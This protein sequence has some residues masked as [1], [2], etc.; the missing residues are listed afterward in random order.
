MEYLISVVVPIYNSAPYIGELINSLIKQTKSNFEIVFIDDNSNDSSETLVKK[1]LMD[2]DIA[3]TYIYLDI[4]VGPGM[5]RNRALQAVKGDYILFVDSDDW[6]AINTMAILNEAINAYDFDL[7]LFDY[8]RAWNNGKR[9]PCKELNLPE[10]FINPSFYAALTND[11]VTRKLFNRKIIF[12]NNIEFPNWR[13]GE[14]I[15]FS[16]T[17]VSFVDKIYYLNEYLYNY[18]QRE[19]SISNQ[20]IIASDFYNDLY[21]I[22]LKYFDGDT[23]QEYRIVQD[24]L[25]NQPLLYLKTRQNYKKIKK[26][27][28][29]LMESNKGIIKNINM[30]YFNYTKR[31]FIYAAY[32]RLV[33]VLKF[34]WFIKNK[35]MEG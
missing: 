30:H 23:F 12:E 34:L 31:I 25:Y 22:Y 33:L 35:F 19:N 9:K 26:Y 1:L 17:Y 18:L 7:L 29:N 3:F 5:A 14:D 10:G 24:L 2:A 15:A 16:I 28:T 6:L 21:K 8:I 11:G 27:L 32:F 4:N 13:N 20:N